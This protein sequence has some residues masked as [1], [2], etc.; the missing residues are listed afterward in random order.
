M[1]RGFVFL[2][3]LWAFGSAFAQQFETFPDD[4]L[5]VKKTV[6]ANGMQVFLIEDHAQPSV[7]GMVVVKAGGKYDPKDATGMGHYLEHMLF[8][9]TQNLGTS[10]YAK[11][12]PFLDRI[13][14]LY[15]VLGKTTDDAERKAIQLKIN[16]NAV[17]AAAYAIPNEL[18]RLIASIGGRGLN[19]FTQEE[20]IAYHNSFPPNQIEK[21]LDIYA[22]RFQ[23]P[24]FRLFQSE[25]E[26][27]YEEKN[28]AMDGF[29][30]AIFRRFSQ[31]FYKNHPYGQQDVLGETEHLKNP[32][33][34][35]MY[36]YYNTYYVANNM[37]IVLS[38]D[39]DANVVL[40]MIQKKFGVLKQG[41]VP[42]YPE[43]PEAPFKGREYISGHFTPIKAGIVGFRTVPNGHADE[44][45]LDVANHLLFNENETGFLNK[46]TFDQKL[47]ACILQALPY[48]DHGASLLIIIPKLIGQSLKEAEGLAMAEFEKVKK[49]EFDEGALNAAKL[50]LQLD[51]ERALENNFSRANYVAEAFAQ[52]RSWGDFAAYPSE[53]E[54]VTKAQVMAV[55]NKYYGPN[56][57]ILESKMG[58]PK[59]EKLEKPGYVAPKPAADT[60]SEYAKGFEQLPEGKPQ[61]HFLD[62][63]KDVQQVQ[64]ADNVKLYRCDNPVNTIFQ[65]DLRFGRGLMD[66]PLLEMAAEYMS[67][68]GTDTKT[69]AD[70][71]RAFEWIGCTY[72]LGATDQYLEM[73]LSGVEGNLV[74]AIQLLAELC[75]HAK[76]DPKKVE[77]L[78]KGTKTDRKLETREGQ[79]M[80]QMTLNYALY[81][82]NS[83]YVRR[84]SLK[85]IQST[86]AE[87]YIARFQK[88]LLSGCEIYYSGK[89]GA[90]WVAD[91][92]KTQ[93]FKGKY[94]VQPFAYKEKQR[95]AYSEPTVIFLKKGDAIQTQV[96][97]FKESEPFDA[98]RIWL[99]RCFNE[100]FGG[101]SGIVFQEI[102]E[103]RSL[104]YTATARM[105]LP[106]LATGRA[107]LSGYIG[108][109][110]DK[111]QEAMQVMN[112]LLT[113]MPQKPERVD[114]IQKAVVQ[115]AYMSR[116]EFRY[117]C[118]TMASWQRL[119]Y[120]SDP[121][122]QNIAKYAGLTWDLLWGYC[123]AAVLKN[124][125][126]RPLVWVIT[127]DPKRVSME[128]LK[129]YGKV[130]EVTEK[131]VRTE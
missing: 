104:A 10:D 38:G 24:V 124:E 54:A 8:K 63:E 61:P 90:D 17:S 131:M 129:K 37:A 113:H 9:G 5:G 30:Y 43:Y 95:I 92:L 27:V 11:E 87:D 79:T 7:F 56:Y 65:L 125:G 69:T 1:K 103:F 78:A 32:S 48:N 6:L 75:E 22:E 51:F 93:F 53:L 58:F 121:T 15:E 83:D 118:S 50:N 96:H 45:A 2:L 25:L 31:S 20:M 57:L 4:P 12:K 107:Y 80:G 122:S 62:F 120:T 117:A 72:S 110:G 59:K 47:M 44:A 39:F 127:G 101:M 86:K 108:C 26:T 76:A 18:D 94:P 85:M 102:R 115:A 73:S 16:E 98:N 67:L 28:R 112:D 82:A 99:A 42:A 60:K 109:Q 3:V 70:L 71:K 126:D 23:N 34:T 33:L 40:P 68:I 13:D 55:A 49:G 97:F 114:N 84:P 123:Q 52:N 81:G 41:N 89:K 88:A 64:I 105:N 116:P 111:T 91:A 130:V 46:L 106:Q 66:D 128:E 100:Y 119:G 14:S 74:Q 21:W 35:K 29:E 77:L 36:E 19:A